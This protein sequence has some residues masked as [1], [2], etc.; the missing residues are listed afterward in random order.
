MWVE[1]K[2]V[3]GRLHIEIVLAQLPISG[4]A[5]PNG[6]F[7]YGFVGIAVEGFAK[8][9]W[10]NRCEANYLVGTPVKRFVA[11]HHISMHKLLCRSTYHEVVPEV[12]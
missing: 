11:F 3:N 1:Q 4:Y 5:S 9:G 8:I 12:G 2:I 6:V 7:L 10:R